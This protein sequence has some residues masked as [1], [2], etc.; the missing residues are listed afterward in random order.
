VRELPRWL[1]T[2]L[3]AGLRSWRLFHA[4]APGSAEA[5]AARAVPAL[6]D[7]EADLEDDRFHAYVEEL[8]PVRARE[9]ALRGEMAATQAD[10]AARAR[11]AAA[12]AE[13]AKAEAARA[14]ASSAAAA[15]AAAA[16]ACATRAAL[17]AWRTETLD[18]LGSDARARQA[19]VQRRDAGLAVLAALG[20]LGAGARRTQARLARVP[21]LAR[22]LAAALELPVGLR[23]APAWAAEALLFVVEGAEWRARA[24]AGVEPRADV[25]DVAAAAGA[26]VAAHAA[27]HEAAGAAAGGAPKPEPRPLQIGRKVLRCLGPLA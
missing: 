17:A 1:F 18:R 22:R 16:A 24:A 19:A 25:A 10:A 9:L 21:G 2:E 20:S 6:F 14:S 4:P 23:V 27:A 11:A 13:A 5:R 15:A 12:K 7:P 26:F 8:A 3:Q